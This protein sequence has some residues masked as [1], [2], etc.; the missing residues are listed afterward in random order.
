MISHRKG[1]S[2]FRLFHWISLVAIVVLVAACSPFQQNENSA[3]NSPEPAKPEK[4]ERYQGEKSKAVSMVYTTQR[5][6]ALTFNG[7][8]D[9][10]TMKRLLDELDKY[11]IKAAF[12]MPG[13]RVAEEPDIARE[14][15]ARGHEIENNTLNKSDLQGQP[16]EKMYKD[17]KLT[18]EIIQR[19]T[20]KTPRYVRTDSGEY[21]DDLRLVA[22]H[23]GQ[24]AVV[25][26]SL[27]LHNW[28]KETGAD[29]SRYLRKYMNRGGIIAM[30]TEENKSLI[31]NIRLL[32]EAATNVGY[33][34]VPLH[35]L[36][37][38]GGERKPLQEIPGF[39]AA[40]MNAAY[41]ESKPNLIYRKETDKK[42]VAL[43]FDD[44]GTDQT[45][46]KILDILNKK[47]VKASFFLRADGV[48]RNPNLA[49]AIAEAGHDVA[50]H[51][52]SHPVNTKI[53]PEELQKEIVKAHQI[54][55]EAIQQK[56]TMYFRPPTGAF[57][58]QTLKAIAATGYEDITIY[59]VTPSDYDKKRSANEIVKD[60]M[61]QTRSG[62]VILLHMLDDIHT[63]EALPIVIDQLRSKGYTLVPMTEMFGQ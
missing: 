13:M 53:A 34:F 20:D 52:Y 3:D 8:A 55:T 18:N 41:N 14:I 12:F 28:Q 6:L 30:D 9:K 44:W 35:E 22:A 43:S 56:P 17:I 58:E 19:E 61:E 63:T 23:N 5:Q 10:D 11:H 51:T 33:R 4:I 29:K 26:S 42:M 15:V 62:S 38:Q 24:E 27:F 49:R 31:E 47:G 37:A 45:V 7:M 50:N 1:A 59:D 2:G 48:E 32:A 21:N 60:I 36:I 57:D 54:I 25:S 40:K 39:D 46:T 16:Y